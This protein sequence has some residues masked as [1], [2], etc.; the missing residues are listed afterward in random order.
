MGGLTF[1]ILFFYFFVSLFLVYLA[2]SIYRGDSLEKLFVSE[3]LI[4]FNTYFTSFDDMVMYNEESFGAD[5]NMR[6]GLRPK[7]EGIMSFYL[8]V[9]S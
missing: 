6:R 5:K 2:H 1:E 4:R 9:Q 7:R 3:R 8:G